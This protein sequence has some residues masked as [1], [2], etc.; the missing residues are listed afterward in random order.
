MKISSWIFK[1]A[2]TVLVI[3]LPLQVTA[4]SRTVLNTTGLVAH[5]NEHCFVKG[6]VSRVS[7]H[8]I[9]NWI[10]D[11]DGVYPNE[12]FTVVIFKPFVYRFQNLQNL[13]GQT[14]IFHGWVV[15]AKDGGPKMV[16][17]NPSQIV[18]Q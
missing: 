13:V 5:L 9:G 7:K 6:T 14:L 10:L 18:V 17:E 12:A 3:G 2:I 16:L 1:L 4:E 11:I 15:R 8:G